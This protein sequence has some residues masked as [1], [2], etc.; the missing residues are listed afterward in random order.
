MMSFHPAVPAVQ[1][2][3]H[4]AIMAGKLHASAKAPDHD[5]TA[6]AGIRREVQAEGPSG[7]GEGGGIIYGVCTHSTRGCSSRGPHRIGGALR[8]RPAGASDRG[9]G[10][11]VTVLRV[12][13]SAATVLCE[14]VIETVLW[15]SDMTVM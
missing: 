4:A 14:T 7:A 2:L 12:C 6:G 8:A 13:D 5:R 11:T 15:D 9:C 3:R 10:N 1:A